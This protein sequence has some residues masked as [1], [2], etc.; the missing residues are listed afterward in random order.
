MC[1]IKFH[2]KMISAV[3]DVFSMVALT[4]YYK[5]PAFF[6]VDYQYYCCAV[7]GIIGMAI[8]GGAAAV[9]AGAVVGLGVALSRKK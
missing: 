7:D 3:F 5:T 2:S 8:V 1:S 4:L 6:T 9:V